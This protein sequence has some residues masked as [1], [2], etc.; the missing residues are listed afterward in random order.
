MQVTE[1]LVVTLRKPCPLG[2]QQRQEAICESRRILATIKQDPERMIPWAKVKQK[3][4]VKQQGSFQDKPT[5]VA[6]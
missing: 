2:T 5:N 3:L 1:E 6:A 4:Q